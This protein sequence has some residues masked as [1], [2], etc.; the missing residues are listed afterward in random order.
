MCESVSKK[1]H[2]WKGWR[3]LPVPKVSGAL[4][5]FIDLSHRITEELSRIPSFP[6]P[7]IRQ[8]TTIP[9]HR[10]NVTEV[11]MVVHHGTHLDAPR[12]FIA[13]GPTIDQIPLE[14]LYG[15]G[16]I[17][18]IDVADC[19]LLDAADLV[20]ATPRMQEGD[21]VLLD[22]GRARYINTEKYMNHPS[23]TAAAA[24]WLV[25]RGAKIVGVDFATPDLAAR[26]RP[27]DFA[28]PV[29]YA[30]L[31]QGILIAEHVTNLGSLAGQRAEIMFLGLNVAGSDGAQARVIAR[32]IG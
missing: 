18:R 27:S 7:R 19:G 31:S 10:A 1:S 13:D 12:H 32:P 16:V 26:L 22:T 2:G 5:A 4:G 29:H 11:Q 15:P 6:Q 14:R 8:I 20:L 30:L 24:E 21:I 23:L 17:W 28:F 3:D 9:Q 25:K